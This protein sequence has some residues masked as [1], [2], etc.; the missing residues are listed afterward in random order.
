MVLSHPSGSRVSTS[1]FP[2]A[3]RGGEHW[4]VMV[5]AEEEM[6]NSDLDH[7]LRT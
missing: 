7:G 6:A 5:A 3:S 2:A 4:V 1:S